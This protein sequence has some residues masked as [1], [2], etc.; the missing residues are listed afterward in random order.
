MHLKGEGLWKILVEFEKKL[1]RLLKD[2]IFRCVIQTVLS[3]QYFKGSE[4]EFGLFKSWWAL[5]ERH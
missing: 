3:N 5:V 4:N 2:L 1:T